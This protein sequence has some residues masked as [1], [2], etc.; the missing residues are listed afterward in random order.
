MRRALFLTLLVSCGDDNSV[1]DL[2]APDLAVA[3]LAV[4]DLTPTHDLAGADL[5]GS[6]GGDGGLTC[7]AQL[8][9][10][11]LYEDACPSGGGTICFIDHTPTDFF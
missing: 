10:T 2:A 8:A 5:A 3:D 1:A 6:D 7:V 4:A 11:H 9:P